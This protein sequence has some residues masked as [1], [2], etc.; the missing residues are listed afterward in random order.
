MGSSKDAANQLALSLLDQFLSTSVGCL[1]AF[2]KSFCVNE[3]ISRLIAPD[4]I[5]AFYPPITWD[6][7][8]ALPP[9]LTFTPMATAMLITGT[10]TAPGQWGFR[11]TLTDARGTF[12]YRTYIVEV[13]EIDE[14]A[15]L[16]DGTQDDA[17]SH[18]ISTVHGWAPK[19][20]ALRSGDLLPTGLT[21]DGNSGVISGTPESPGTYTFHVVVT[22][23]EGAICEK[24]FTLLINPNLFITLPWVFLVTITNAGI[25][26]ATGGGE[27]IKLS[28]TMSGGNPHALP[29]GAV[30]RGG[31]LIWAYDNT[32]GAPLNCNLRLEV[33]RIENVPGSLQN[34]SDGLIWE[35]T[36]PGGAIVYAN[37][38][39]TIL[40]GT[41][42]FPF[43]IPIGLSTWH[44]GGHLALGETWLGAFYG[45]TDTW[46]L[47]VDII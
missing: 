29:N 30:C 1:T 47:Y 8:G 42:N 46:D 40:T 14:G 12:T 36:S 19:T 20:F 45:G 37:M 31:F 28:A 32:T 9:G 25:G 11:L 24:E 22:D 23:A 16:P 4:K 15:T 21:L 27:H 18:A 39:G 5:A 10:F 26:T 13:M 2:G 33:Q 38:N 35:R 17:Y 43:T 44:G 34:G 3:D 41:Y 7:L 6:V